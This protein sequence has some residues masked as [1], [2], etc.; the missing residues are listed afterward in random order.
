MQ[1]E[2]KQCKDAENYTPYC[3]GDKNK[4]SNIK[5]K[6]LSYIIEKIKSMYGYIMQLKKSCYL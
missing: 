4:K 2:Y 6:S 1:R 5:K 3:G